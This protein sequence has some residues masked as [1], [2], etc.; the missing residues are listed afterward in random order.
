MVPD[1]PVLT[2]TRMQPADPADT[3]K[4]P[5]RPP[6]I[7]QAA[8]YARGGPSVAAPE[9]RPASVRGIGR[10]T[11]AVSRAAWVVVLDSLDGLTPAEVRQ[12]ASG[13]QGRRVITPP[14][15]PSIGRHLGPHTPD[16]S[17]PPLKTR[18]AAD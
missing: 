9:D 16:A 14:R 10:R 5:L 7:F 18:P 6:V 12:L 3:L 2:P 15:R 17:I 4:T 13:H 8:T 1:W 11:L